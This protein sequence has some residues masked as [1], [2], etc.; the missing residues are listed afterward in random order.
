[1]PCTW[2]APARTAASVLATAFSVSLWAWM[3]SW[4]GGIRRATCSTVRRD[5]VR[6]AA[7][8]GVAQHDPA[9]AAVPGR[10]EAGER[11][12]GIGA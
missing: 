11:V 7:A 1:M 4:S 10:L 3:P 12:A 8:V 2:R 6:Q 9:R 5:L